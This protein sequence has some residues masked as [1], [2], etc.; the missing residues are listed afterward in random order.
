MTPSILS[1]SVVTSLPS[2]NR[3]NSASMLMQ[4]VTDLVVPTQLSQSLLLS[5]TKDLSSP[6]GLIGFFSFCFPEEEGTR[7][8]PYPV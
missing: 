5:R 4:N 1:C 7:L 8:K 2:M 3:Q 6:Q